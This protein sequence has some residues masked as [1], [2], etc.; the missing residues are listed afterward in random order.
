MNKYH[1]LLAHIEDIYQSQRP[2]SKKIYEDA[3][4]YLPGGDTRTATYFEPYPHF[5]ERGQGPYIF[6][7]DGNKLIDFQ[8]NYT[9]LIHGH[10]H[11]PTKEAIKDQLE[12]GQAYASP[13]ELQVDL[14]KIL[15]QRFPGIDLVRFT[16]SGTEANMH[17][18]RA[19]RAFTGKTKIVKTEGGY[20]GTTDVFEASVDP[21]LKKAGSIDAIK[22][23]AESRGVSENALK[24][25]IV[26][27]FNDI[28]RTEKILQ[29]YSKEIAC[30]IVEPIM[31]SAGQ[32]L[33]SQEYLEFLRKI[34]SKYDILLIFDEVVTGR[35]KLGGAQEHYGVIPDL[36]TLGKI[37]GGGTPFGAFG[38]R[39]DIMKL[40]DPREK[41]MYHS[42]TFNGNGISMAAGLAT[43]S[44]YGSE[45]IEYVNN[46]GGFLKSSFESVFNEVGL[47]IQLNGIGSIYNII[48]SNKPIIQYRDMATSH[49]HLNRLLFMSLLIRGVF[50]APRGMFCTST[51]MRESD[52]SLAT[53]ALRDSLYEM[54]DVISEE[55]PELINK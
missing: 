53:A 31:A 22:V 54:K 14:A 47:N 49:E 27:P 26:V 36:T 9:A 15:V 21:N 39:G 6:D 52:I 23:L 32:I 37:I 18:I 41:K 28:E 29:E 17:A 35:L 33:P 50:D 43:L 24:D 3:I 20:H 13:F 4:L 19:A 12:K 51:A 44:H 30:I 11:I 46:L 10:G 25:V 5:I 16:N 42:G 1:E 55:A 48:F 34:T 38:G 45:E 2:K 8:N 7:I 40:Y